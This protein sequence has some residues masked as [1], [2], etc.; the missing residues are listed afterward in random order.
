MDYQSI[1]KIYYYKQLK[2]GFQ[3][4]FGDEKQPPL[5]QELRPLSCDFQL[6]AIQNGEKNPPN[7]AGEYCFDRVEKD[8]LSLEIGALAYFLSYG[9]F[10]YSQAIRKVNMLMQK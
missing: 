6:A 5:L 4:H 10:G 2:R 9:L 8:N 7:L 1:G 3:G